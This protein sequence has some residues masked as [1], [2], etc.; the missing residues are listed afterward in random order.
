MK[1]IPHTFYYTYFKNHEGDDESILKIPNSHL[2]NQRVCNLSRVR[3]SQ[4]KQTIRFK[5]SDMEKIPD[6]ISSLKEEMKKAFSATLITQDRPF[7][8]HFRDIEA[9]HLEV[10]CDFRFNLPPTGDAYYDNRQKVIETIAKVVK[11]KGK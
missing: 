8:V 9:N 2:V 1:H 10:V 3:R 4:V 6:F 11:N 5:Y 7:R